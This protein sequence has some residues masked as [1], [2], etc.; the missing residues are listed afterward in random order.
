MQC[1]D[2]YKLLADS[3]KLTSVAE[4][5]LKEFAGKQSAQRG[6]LRSCRVHIHFSMQLLLHDWEGNTGEYSVRGWQYWF[7]RREGQYI[8]RELNIPLYCPTQKEC[9]NIFINSGHPLKKN[10]FGRGGERKRK[11]KEK[12]KDKNKKQ[13]HW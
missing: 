1:M 9:N 5:Q 13:S 12:E 8:N 7:D 11:R 10:F 4:F 2:M 3:H 6:I